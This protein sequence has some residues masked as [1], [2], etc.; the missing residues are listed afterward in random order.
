MPKYGINM[1]ANRK[2]S[3][4]LSTWPHVHLV[5]TSVPRVS[6]KTMPSKTCLLMRAFSEFMI[7]VIVIIVTQIL[8]QKFKMQ[9]TQDDRILAGL[10]ACIS[11][12]FYF[13]RPCGPL[14]GILQSFYYKRK[15]KQEE[16][17]GGKDVSKCRIC[18][19][20]ENYLFDMG[21]LAFHCV[22][23]IL[24]SVE[25]VVMRGK[26][27]RCIVGQVYA[28]Y[29]ILSSLLSLGLI[30]WQLRKVESSKQADIHQGQNSTC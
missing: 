21:P 20:C 28:I 12:L 17:K 13:V 3:F 16:Q 18:E 11:C 25:P 2:C 5:S 23:L 8:F 30:L 4:D 27:Y 29:R 6:P 9:Q 7:C 10:F 19:L 26:K 1:G 15:S 24:V 22:M 14:F